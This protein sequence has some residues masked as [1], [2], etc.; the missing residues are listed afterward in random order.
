MSLPLATGDRIDHYEI[1][2][3]MGTGGMAEVYKARDTRLDRFVAVKVSKR[4]FIQ[5]FESEMRMVAA[6]NHPNICTLHDVGILPS[7][8][9]YLVMELVE[10]STLTNRIKRG[11]LPTDEA[12]KIAK[13]IAAAIEAAH[14]KN[15]IHCDLKPG[16][17]MIKADGMVKVLDFGLAQFTRKPGATAINET[18][19]TTISEPAF[20]G[21]IVGTVPYMAP[22]QFSSAPLDKRVDIWAFGVILYEML[23]GCPPFQGTTAQQVLTGILSEKP[24]FSRVPAVTRPVI[25]RCLVKDRGN[26]LRNIWDVWSLLENPITDGHLHTA[27]FTK[28]G[29]QELFLTRNE[30]LREHDF[31]SLC[32][33]MG[34]KG[35]IR[36]IGT[37][38]FAIMVLT[39]SLQNALMLGATVELGFL[40]PD[41][42]RDVFEI[43]KESIRENEL[44]AS[45]A[46]LGEELTDWVVAATPPG[47]LEVRFHRLALF[48][49]LA[50]FQTESQTFTVWDLSFGANLSKKKLFVLDQEKPLAKDLHHRYERI[51]LRGARHFKYPAEPAVQ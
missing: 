31:S 23:L 30:Y 7:G 6:L 33:E 20:L 13:Q 29:I 38:L 3:L 17:I 48:D 12:L 2:R 34:P 49:S 19:P 14:E 43:L 22:E 39:E 51:W 44:H 5:H 10:G 18:S 24:V 41:A 27:A 46:R 32:S 16:N 26:R 21:T 11:A 37:S 36:V 42:P 8:E 1:L 9:S 35:R 47:S 25:E 15:I 28:L 45:L 40:D 50:E 4:E